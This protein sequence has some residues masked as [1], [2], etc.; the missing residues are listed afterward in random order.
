MKAAAGENPPLTFLF[1]Q[2]FQMLRPDIPALIDIAHEEQRYEILHI[3][4]LS[5]AVPVM[6]IQRV[7]Y[8]TR[9][10]LCPVDWVPTLR[11]PTVREVKRVRADLKELGFTGIFLRLEP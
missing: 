1:A 9:H 8:S 5:L 10:L 7:Q 3:E 6:G 11:R 4:F 2:E